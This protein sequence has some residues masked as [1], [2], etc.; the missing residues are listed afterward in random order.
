MSDSTYDEWFWVWIGGI[1]GALFVYSLIFG[2]L[3]DKLERRA[4]IGWIVGLVIWTIVSASAFAKS[5]VE[6]FIMVGSMAGMVGAGLAIHWLF[7]RR[8][9]SG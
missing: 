6:L 7:K 4:W 9:K 8:R 5:I 2:G 1:I 3:P